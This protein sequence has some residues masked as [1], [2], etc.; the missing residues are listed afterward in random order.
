M[1]E[2]MDA[3]WTMESQKR[4]VANSYINNRFYGPIH[5]DM[6]LSRQQI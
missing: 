6:D 3:M 2:L 4:L 1:A 5:K